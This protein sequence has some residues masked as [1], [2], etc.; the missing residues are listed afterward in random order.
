MNNTNM[1]DGLLGFEKNSKEHF[2]NLQGNLRRWPHTSNRKIRKEWSVKLSDALDAKDGELVEAEQI[3]G[4][5]RLVYMR[6]G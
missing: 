1:R 6:P 2:R 4:K 3:K 5:E